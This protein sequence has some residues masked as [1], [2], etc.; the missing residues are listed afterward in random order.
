MKDADVKVIDALM[1]KT[2]E[3]T[4]LKIIVDG[5]HKMVDAEDTRS[6]RKGWRCDIETDKIRDAF[7]WSLCDAAKNAAIEFEAEQKRK[8][9][10]DGDSDS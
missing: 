6:K 8:E 2:E 1:T 10:E 4:R 7:G 3:L 9:Q 5:F